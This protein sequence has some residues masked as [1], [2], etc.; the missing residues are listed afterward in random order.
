MDIYILVCVY[1]FV[2]VRACDLRTTGR[3]IMGAKNILNKVEQRN[4]KYIL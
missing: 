2:R 3:T 4:E 1:L